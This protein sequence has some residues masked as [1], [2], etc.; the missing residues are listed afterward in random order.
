M[1]HFSQ[2]TT[3]YLLIGAVVTGLWAAMIAGLL[4]R[5]R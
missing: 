1:E 3:V 2:E 5:T 4:R